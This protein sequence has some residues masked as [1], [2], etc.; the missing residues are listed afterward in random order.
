MTGAC[1]STRVILPGTLASIAN[2]SGLIFSVFEK[3]AGR[4][5]TQGPQFVH[6]RLLAVRGRHAIT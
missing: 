1:R 2:Q 5:S 3:V 4:S 6:A